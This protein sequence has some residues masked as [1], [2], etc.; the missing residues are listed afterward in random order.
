MARARQR[1]PFKRLVWF[2]R[3]LRKEG[4]GAFL[5]KLS[6]ALFSRPLAE[7]VADTVLQ[8]HP[9]FM[10]RKD[11]V[12]FTQ[13][14]ISTSMGFKPTNIYKAKSPRGLKLHIRHAPTYSPFFTYDTEW[15][16]G[17]ERIRVNTNK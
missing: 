10:P 4:I 8:Q 9:G 15:R 12:S 13:S 7:K 14:A 5:G 11:L 6:Y 16:E 2:F 3:Y 1:K 17:I